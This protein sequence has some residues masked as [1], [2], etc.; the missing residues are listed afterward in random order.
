MNKMSVTLSLCASLLWGC[1][2]NSSK[3]TAT[4]TA[5]IPIEEALK[6]P[7][8]ILLSDLGQKPVY[9][10]LETTDSSLVDI[11]S[12]T[13]MKVM[14]DVIL[15][16]NKNHPIKVFNK[17]TGRYLREIGR[18]GNGP[19]EYANG[20]LFHV[21]AKTK[22]I[23]VEVS[24]S[25]RHIYNVNGDL[26][27]TITHE[28]PIGTL[29]APLFWDNKLYNFVTI[30]SPQTS[31]FSVIYDLPSQTKLDSLILSGDNVPSSGLEF[32]VP[33][34]G[35]EIFGGRA[36]IMKVKDQVICFG[37]RASSPYWP[38]KDKLHFK[39]VYNDT[40]FTIKDNFSQMEPEYVFA[41]GKWGG[42]KRYET[43][44]NMSDKLLI[45]RVLETDN[46]IY[47][48]MIQNLYDFNNWMKR[49]Y[50]PMYCGIYNK[51]DGTVKVSKS[52]DIENDLATFPKFSICDVSTE[53][54]LI[55]CYQAEELVDAR[56]NIPEAEQPEWL[57]K[58]KEDDNPVFLM[59]K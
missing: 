52:V 22:Y 35:M 7:Q 27:K 8:K 50:P 10:P 18:I 58:L 57:K 55:A 5:V 38:H 54:E 31:C 21:D 20:N 17:A 47:F 48:V 42:F 37:Y 39:D 6:Q 43:E 46:V 53:G 34:S 19:G 32:V 15:I 23:Y 41:L 30:P 29:T 40:I 13:A 14:D 12:T 49:V 1:S 51:K 45:S 33:L 36:F 3:G 44:D 4:S 9:L 2:G 11:S 16:G 24:P 59:I 25:Q 26:I 28:N 56:Q